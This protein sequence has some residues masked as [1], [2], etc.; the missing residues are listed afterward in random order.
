MKR[1]AF[2]GALASGGATA[3]AGC[4]SRRETVQRVSATP[5]IP[6]GEFYHQPLRI[7][8]PGKQFNLQYEVTADAPFDVLVF[9][10]Q[11]DPEAF[12]TYRAL[13]GGSKS[14]D[15]D[16]TDTMEPR[17]DHGRGGDG[18][19]HGTDGSG[20]NEQHRRGPGG[21]SNR[22]Q[23]SDWHSVMG[24]R[25]RGEV[26]RPLRPGLHHF[27]VD[28]TTFGEAGPSGTLRPTVDLAVRDF[29]MVPG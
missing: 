17:G 13:V 24:A 11:S 16:R 25:G 19:R 29:E 2:L 6:S 1:R 9:G 10:G 15:A 14:A 4:T 18:R 26:N 3:L 5:E 20:G 22:P 12:E 28:N 23:P 7:D 27:V 21:G 8:E